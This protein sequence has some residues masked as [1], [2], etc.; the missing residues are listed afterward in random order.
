[1]MQPLLQVMAQLQSLRAVKQGDPLPPTITEVI[2]GGP[3]APAQPAPAPVAPAEPMVPPQPAPIPAPEVQ[4]I[5]IF[6]QLQPLSHRT[7]K[8]FASSACKMCRVLKP[9]PLSFLA[10]SA[11]VL[12]LHSLSLPVRPAER[13]F[14]PAYSN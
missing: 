7:A 4:F 10:L 5:A 11:Q 3:L 12:S 2:Q 1:M 9:R 6:L 14:K 8:K 13:L